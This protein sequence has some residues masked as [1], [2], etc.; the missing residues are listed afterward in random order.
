MVC[1]L[2]IRLLMEKSTQLALMRMHQNIGIKDRLEEHLLGDQAI[3]TLDQHDDHLE[4]TEVVTKDQL[5]V[6][7]LD[8]QAINV[9][10]Q[11]DDHLEKTENQVSVRSVRKRYLTEKGRQY[12][13]TILKEKE[14]EIISTVD[15]E[16]CLIG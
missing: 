16:I 2:E 9:L 10:D 3:S 14:T 1:C 11:H 15:E 13:L 6:Y 8:D 7:G 4:R 12:Q 5:M